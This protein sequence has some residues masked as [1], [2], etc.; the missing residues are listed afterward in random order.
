M[1]GV[2]WIVAGRLPLILGLAGITGEI[3]VVGSATLLGLITY[4]LLATLLRVE[5]FGLIWT[6]V[7]QKLTSMV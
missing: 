2:V 6:R 7:Q 5:E 1:G 4:G 3:I